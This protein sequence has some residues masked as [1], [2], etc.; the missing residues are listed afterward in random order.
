MSLRKV[1]GEEDCCLGKLQHSQSGLNGVNEW[2]L[3][4]RLLVEVDGELVVA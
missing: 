3:R 1:L 2:I 4:S